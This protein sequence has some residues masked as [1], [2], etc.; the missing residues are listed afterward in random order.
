[1]ELELSRSKATFGYLAWQ[2]MQVGERTLRLTLQTAAVM[3]TLPRATV[4]RVGASHSAQA[5]VVLLGLIATGNHLFAS[6]LGNRALYRETASAHSSR[7][8]GGS[9]GRLIYRGVSDTW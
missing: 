8:Q 4:S 7:G 5:L 1:M 2:P 3:L 6:T 9:I